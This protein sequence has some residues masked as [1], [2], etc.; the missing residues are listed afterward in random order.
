MSIP[1]NIFASVVRQGTRFQHFDAPAP[2]V[3][4]PRCTRP[5]DPNS[6]FRT[7]NPGSFMASGIL[8]VN[9]TDHFLRE[10]KV[11]Y[12]WAKEH[13]KGILSR[14][15]HPFRFC[16]MY[17]DFFWGASQHVRVPPESCKIP[18]KASNTHR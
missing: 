2:F 3:W 11:T 15:G 18:L 1:F 6:G 7:F 17:L 9:R 4:N 8:T 13:G 12:F 14:V 5:A 16:L 10:K